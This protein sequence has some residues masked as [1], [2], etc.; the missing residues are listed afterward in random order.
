MDSLFFA[1]GCLIALFGLFLILIP[2][3]SSNINNYII[4]CAEKGGVVI[5]MA[6]LY[7]NSWVQCVDKQY[8]KEIVIP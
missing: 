5:K 3:N 8:I 7:E 6:K 2:N 1:L 4:R